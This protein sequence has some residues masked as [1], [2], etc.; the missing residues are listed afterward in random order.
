MGYEAT[1]TY[2]DTT[3]KLEITESENGFLS[4]KLKESENVSINVQYTGT[5]LE[6]AGYI[7]SILG[8]IIFILYRLKEGKFNERKEEVKKLHE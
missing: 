2:G 7:V 5:I 1:A 8:I 6:K 3:E 4:V